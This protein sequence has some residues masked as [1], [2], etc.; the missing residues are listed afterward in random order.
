MKEGFGFRNSNLG[1]EFYMSKVK[2]KII[3]MDCPSCAMLIESELEDVGIEA[4]VSYAKQVL[5]IDDSVDL[6]KTVKIISG[7]GYK[8]EK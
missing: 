4:R 5:E 8:I 6:E 1:F 7:L 3:G 2:Y